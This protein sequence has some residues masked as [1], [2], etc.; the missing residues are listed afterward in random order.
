MFQNI[1]GQDIQQEYEETD[2]KENK[3]KKFLK[4]AFTPR[5]NINIYSMFYAI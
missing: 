5:K 2:Y 4:V 1:Q 3:I